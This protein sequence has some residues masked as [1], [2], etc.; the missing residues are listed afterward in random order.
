[1]RAFW[2]R[3]AISYLG[4]WLVLR[5]LLAL[6]A[7]DEPP[8]GRL[9]AIGI[10]FGSDLQALL[11]VFGWLSAGFL[12]GQRF[13]VFW[14]GLTVLVVVVGFVADILYWSEFQTRLGRLV[15][16]YVRYVREVV[17]FIEDQLH[18]SYFV[19]PLAAVTWLIARWQGR[20]LPPAFSRFHRLGFCGWVAAA[21][22]VLVFG[23]HGPVG[24]SRPLNNLGSNSY[25][26]ILFATRVDLTEWEGAYWPPGDEVVPVRVLPNRPKA[27]PPAR[28]KHL[29]LVIEESFGGELWWDLEQRGEYMPQLA[30]IAERGLYLDRIYATGSRTIRGLEAILNGYPPLPGV[31]LSQREG[32][33]RLPS[34]PRVL[35]EAGVYTSFVY[36]GWPGFTS[37]FDYWR[38]IGF[39][40]ML[41]RYDFEDR[42]FE[43]S[44]GVADE[45][46]F[47]RVLKEMDRLTALHDR[48]M[49]ATLTVT[50]HLPFDFPAGRIDH[51]SDERRQKYAVAYADWALGEFIRQAHEH[52]W[53]ADTLVVVVAD[54]GPDG[55]GSPLVPA[56]RFRVPLVLYN[57][58]RLAPRVISNHGS[59]MSLAVTLLELLG[60]PATERLYGWNLLAGQDT[61]AP[62]EED[63]HFG[64]LG[65]DRLTVLARGGEVYGWGYDGQRLRPGRPDLQQARQAAALFGEAHARFYGAEP[66]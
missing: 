22:L 59:S 32:F 44:W 49:L 4:L 15:V 56:D 6:M 1:M 21:A 29:L 11:L 28:F 36:G 33:E 17:A 25:L 24:P 37:F 16:H 65:P 9:A 51:P 23:R 31:A 47:D 10:G 66:P 35:G 12:A 62:V 13:A 46:L 5:V 2:I 48:V 57:P 52:P 45:I 20:W 7:A 60:A 39:H 53:F 64:L 43:T 3:C 63:Y 26:E 30:A 8:I 61:L 54:H 14:L 18:L 42:W 55:L 58:T 38:G 19:L 40:E 27:P 41:S 34:L 50:N